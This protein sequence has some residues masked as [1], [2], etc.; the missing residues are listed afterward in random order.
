M[1]DNFSPFFIVREPFPLIIIILTE[2][3]FTMEKSFTIYFKALWG[4]GKKASLLTFDQVGV[5]N[6]IDI[7]AT[8]S[9]R[10][11]VEEKLTKVFASRPSIKYGD[12]RYDSEYQKF[13]TVVLAAGRASTKL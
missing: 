3:T 11:I 8:E 4:K 13:T 7:L 12:L 9:D 10:S 1:V 5:G 2:R 6:R